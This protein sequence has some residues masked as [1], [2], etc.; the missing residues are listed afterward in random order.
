MRYHFVLL[1]TSF[2]FFVMSI[3]RRLATQP[4]LGPR[5][6]IS[7]P[8]SDQKIA[9]LEKKI[10]NLTSK[11]AEKKPKKSGLRAMFAE[12]GVSFAVWYL[13]HK[14][15][16]GFAKSIGADKIYDLDSI[17]PK[18][19]KFGVAVLVNELSEPLRIPLALL[20]L[21]PAIR[22]FRKFRPL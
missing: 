16:I 13:K 2:F 17:D 6:M 7:R 15:I 21:N 1:K 22:V 12:K 20:T 4:R 8:F 10:D 5:L 11:L 3:I 18:T 14:E 9:E 19:G